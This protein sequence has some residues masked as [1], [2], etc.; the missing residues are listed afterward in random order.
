MSE[1]S[2][3]ISLNHVMD[4]IQYEF[5]AKIRLRNNGLAPASRHFVTVDKM[6]SD[7]IKAYALIQP[8]R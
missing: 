5:S 2:F 7:Q 1:T 3:L 8:R 6:V 4:I